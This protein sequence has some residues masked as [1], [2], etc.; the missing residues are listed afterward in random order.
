MTE[1]SGLNEIAVDSDN[2]FYSSVTGVLYSK[3]GKMLVKYPH[4]KSDT[5]F[6]VLDTVVAIGGNAFKNARN[7]NTIIFGN[8]LGAIGSTAFIGCNYLS[9][10]TFNGAVPPVLMGMSMFNTN[11]TGFTI[12]VS[13]DFYRHTRTDGSIDNG[14]DAVYFRNEPTNGKERGW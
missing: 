3:D 9:Q 4:G 5:S 12:F 8:S 1:L 11:I 10:I 2:R 13:A 14:P 7:L 6:T